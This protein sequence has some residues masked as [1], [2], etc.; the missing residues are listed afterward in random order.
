[1]KRFV[2]RILRHRWGRRGQSTSEY[3]IVVALVAIGSIAVITLFGNQIREIYRAA[4]D[5]L[6]GNTAARPNDV[7]GGNAR[8]NTGL[9]QFN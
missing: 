4:A 7:G 5:V 6:S 3:I 9:N 2:N 1:M 8:V